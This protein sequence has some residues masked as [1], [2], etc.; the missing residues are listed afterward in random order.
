MS[1]LSFKK[2]QYTVNRIQLDIGHSWTPRPMDDNNAEISSQV[3]CQET[4]MWE[5]LLPDQK[6][7]LR[8][9]VD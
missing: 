5:L 7:H 9:L 2:H 3:T 8:I 1:G 6:F 4:E